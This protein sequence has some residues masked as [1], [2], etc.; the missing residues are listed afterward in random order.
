LVVRVARLREQ[1]V[2]GSS[3][4][5]AAI[6]EVNEQLIRDIDSGAVRLVAFGP[7]GLPP[8]QGTMIIQ[9]TN[10]AS[11][12]E[13]TSRITTLQARFSTP[14]SSEQSDIALPIGKGVRLSNTSDPP[15]GFDQAVA[16]R[17]IDYVI[18][19]DDGRILW[20]NS[21]GP[22]AST[23]FAGMIDWAVTKT[24]RSR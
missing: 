4:T 18:K 19:L 23:T 2:Q 13:Q 16:A 6:R 24:L 20:I 1:A 10:A 5:I 17:G 7:S 12:E 15:P 11:I 21:T 9:V 14:S 3:S 22:A 8:W